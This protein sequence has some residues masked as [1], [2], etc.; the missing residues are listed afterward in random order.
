MKKELRQQVYD[1]FDG[2]CAYTGLKLDDKWQVDHV[3]PRDYYRSFKG[4]DKDPDCI[5]NLMPAL[6]IV[7]HYKRCQ[8]LEQFRAYMQDFHKR[9]KKLPRN[10]VVEKSKKRKIYM[11]QLAALFGITVDKPFDGVFYFERL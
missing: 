5:D 9:L 3:I 11:R 10:P 8:N 6:R 1:K 4:K 7:N 2:R